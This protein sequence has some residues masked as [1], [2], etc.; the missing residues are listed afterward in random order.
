MKR[1]RGFT[2]VELLIVIIIIGVLAAIAIPQFTKAVERSRSGSALV[3]L[4]KIK[5]LEALYYAE[6]GSYTDVEEDFDD[7]FPADTPQWDFSIQDADDDTFT[8]LATRLA[9]DAPQDAIGRTITINQEGTIF[10][11]AW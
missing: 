2:L 6:H 3:S 4:G 5:T 10:K 8:A 9:E 7:G 11:S 1:K